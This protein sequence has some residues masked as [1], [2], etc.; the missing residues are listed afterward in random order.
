MVA[1]DNDGGIRPKR[2]IS[3]PGAAD[4]LTAQGGED[5]PG[6]SPTKGE[7]PLREATLL[8]DA[9]NLAP[10]LGPDHEA[11]P[12]EREPHE[13]IPGSQSGTIGGGGPEAH[14]PDAI[15]ATGQDDATVEP[16]DDAD[17]DRK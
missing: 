4:F 16:G 13:D 9:R 5:H 15:R 17:A 3:G 8:D 12:G 2:T 11:A 10:R 1:A 6:V 14:N 7:G